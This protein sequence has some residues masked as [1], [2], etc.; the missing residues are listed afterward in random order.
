MRIDESRFPLI[1]IS[2]SGQVSDAELAS[3]FRAMDALADRAASA[4]QHYAVVSDGDADFGPVQRKL[5]ADWVAAM[6][7]ERARWD[8]GNFV[9]VASAWARGILTAVRWLTPKLTKV[10]VFST[11]A[12]ALKAAES[13]L[14][15]AR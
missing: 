10:F 11:R 2:W 14:A 5:I 4:R 15:Q 3:F 13:A 9:V 7:A 8:L 6:P 12:E 1:L